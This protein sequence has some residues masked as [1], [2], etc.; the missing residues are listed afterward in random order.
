MW[1][2]FR[3]GWRAPNLRWWSLYR[4]VETMAAMAGAVGGVDSSIPR[5]LAPFL[6]V[7]SMA[8]MWHEMKERLTATYRMV[9][10]VSTY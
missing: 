6:P 7:D 2:G 10:P 8:V 1:Q 3:R 9:V 4:I 5:T